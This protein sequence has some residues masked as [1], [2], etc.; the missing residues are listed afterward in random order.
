MDYKNK[1]QQEKS[2]HSNSTATNSSDAQT[3]I[4]L[5]PVWKHA[6]KDYIFIQ[7]IGVGAYGE[8]VQAKHKHTN[9]IVA[10][11]LLRQ[12]FENIYDSKK[13][14]REIQIMRHLTQ[15]QNNHFTIKIYDIIIPENTVTFD[16]LFIVME[17]MQTDMKKIF[18]SVPQVA[19]EEIHIIQIIYNLLCS[20]NFMHTANIVHRDIKPGNLLL[21]ADCKVKICDFGLARSLPKINPF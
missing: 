12:L 13:V 10:I 14:I 2:N 11:K 20:L 18:C 3:M 16:Y 7:L 19:L 4:N 1:D 21:D 6:Q 5:S 8:V 17:Y 15:M 9:Q